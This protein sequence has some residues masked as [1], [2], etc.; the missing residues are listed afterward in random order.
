[1]ANMLSVSHCIPQ[2]VRRERLRRTR[3][4]REEGDKEEEE[5]EEEEEGRL[6]PTSEKQDAWLKQVIVSTRCLH[7]LSTK[8]YCTS[9][10]HTH[11]TTLAK[12][13]DTTYMRV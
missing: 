7:L 8:L 10:T 13:L 9:S 4:D 1:M 11:N 2:R 3:E 5:E 6:L 12:Q